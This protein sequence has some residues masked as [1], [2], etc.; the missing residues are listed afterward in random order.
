MTTQ[1]R[2]KADAILSPTDPIFRP[3]VAALGQLALAW[4]GLHETLCLLFCT[5]MEAEAI[6]QYAAIWH[7]LKADRAQREMLAAATESTTRGAL[8]LTFQADVKWLCGRVDA[9]EDLRNDALHS[10]YWAFV[11][12]FNDIVVMPNINLGHVRA[13]KL[14]AKNLLAEFRGCRDSAILLSRFAWQMDCALSDYTQPW[15]D[16]PALPNRPGTNER[17]RR[18]QES[19]AKRLR[20]PR[21]SQA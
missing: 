21:S 14:L 2:T 9:L 5:V 20:P 18:P 6:N 12:G 8:P 15:P 11:R 16:R 19:K 13:K 10:P 3:Y 4:N 1:S 17:K 7:A